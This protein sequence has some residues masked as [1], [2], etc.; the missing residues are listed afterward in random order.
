MALSF[1]DTVACGMGEELIDRGYALAHVQYG[2][3]EP[4]D[5]HR[6]ASA[7]AASCAADYLQTL[8][9]VDARRMA[10]IGHSWLGLTALWCGAMD[11]RFSLSV[12]VNAGRCTGDR[13]ASSIPI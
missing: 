3:V 10:V 8:P 5:G 9:D 4:D 13:I 2:L 11:E 6:A 7:F 1:S 12:G